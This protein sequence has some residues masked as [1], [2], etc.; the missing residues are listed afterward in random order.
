MPIT[1]WSYRVDEENVRHIGPTAQDF[2]TAFG[3]GSDDTTI[4]GVDA[5]GVALAAGQALE[6]LEASVAP[7][8]DR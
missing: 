3:L 4:G 8:P 6:R 7:V 5:A 1:S 2:H